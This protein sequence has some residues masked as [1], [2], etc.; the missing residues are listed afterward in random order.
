MGWEKDRQQGEV[1][2]AKRKANF[3][4]KAEGI[5][6]RANVRRSKRTVKFVEV[7]CDPQINATDNGL[8]E[9]GAVVE[10]GL[11][12]QGAVV[13]NGLGEQGAVVENG[14]GEQGAVSENGLGE[15][16]AVAEI[17]LGEQGAVAEIGLGEQ[18]V[19]VDFTDVEVE[20]SPVE[21]FDVNQFLNESVQA[22]DVRENFTS[23]L[24][25]IDTDLTKCIAM[26]EKISSI[27]NEMESHRDVGINARFADYG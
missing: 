10:N 19:M 1:T 2:M 6:K 17:G 15:Q 9:Q 13:E 7:N 5:N 24:K 4:N 20:A 11:G 26:S 14:L 23:A 16:G 8:G 25:A 27:V 22:D 18:D 3:E 12:E 21:E